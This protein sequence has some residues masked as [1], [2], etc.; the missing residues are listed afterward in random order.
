M[1]IFNVCSGQECDAITRL[2]KEGSVNNQLKIRDS[3]L[4]NFIDKNDTMILLSY[5]T[6]L[7][8]NMNLLNSNNVYIIHQFA[9]NIDA[10]CRPMIN[11]FNRELLNAFWNHVID[12]NA[13]VRKEMG[14][15]FNY[16]RS[17]ELFK[18]NQSARE[19]LKILLEKYPSDYSYIWEIETYKFIELLPLLKKNL[20]LQNQEANQFAESRKWAALIV[21]YSMGDTTVFPLIKD[22]ISK[23]SD[24]FQQ[25]S[26]MNYILDNF[27]SEREKK[28]LIEILKRKDA[29]TEMPE[30]ERSDMSTQNYFTDFIFSKI[31]QIFKAFDVEEIRNKCALQNTNDNRKQ[32]YYTFQKQCLYDETIKWFKE[33]KIMK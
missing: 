22:F 28:Y 23:E 1:S 19:K 20:I 29:L 2:F 25:Y 17:R 31:P 21:C 12:S 11:N 24:V 32:A 7:A 30:D 26:F 6:C 8:R 9:V 4:Q 16:Q 10:I 3:L 33:K 27:N 13:K 18:Y 14:S 15:Y 5:E